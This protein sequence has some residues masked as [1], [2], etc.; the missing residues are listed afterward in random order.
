MTEISAGANEILSQ[1]ESF[2]GRRGDI[3]EFTEAGAPSEMKSPRRE[4]SPLDTVF[5]L[6]RTV[7]DAAVGRKQSQ[8][9][10]PAA[11]GG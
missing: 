3:D 2:I 6:S 9:G 4:W 10:S 5:T 8:A 11:E 7:R 1:L